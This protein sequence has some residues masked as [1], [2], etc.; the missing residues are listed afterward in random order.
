MKSYLQDSGTLQHWNRDFLIREVA[1]ETPAFDFFY[2]T[3][4][5]SIIRKSCLLSESR[6]IP[7]LLQAVDPISFTC[8]AWR[9]A[10]CT[11][12]VV[13]EFTACCPEIM[14]EDNKKDSS[15]L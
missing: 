1:V 11:L 13:T 15:S 3:G 8:K 4:R 2:F 6:H 5:V 9:S 7:F 14:V 10:S 12:P